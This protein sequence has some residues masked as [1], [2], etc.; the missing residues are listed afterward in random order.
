MVLAATDPMA[1][2]VAAAVRVVCGVHNYASYGRPYAFMPVSA[3]LA[4]FYILMLFIADIS[5]RRP[6]VNAYQADFAARQ[7]EVC[8]VALLAH[9]L[10]AGA[11]ASGQLPALT[12]H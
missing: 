8:R 7:F 9:K 6:A 10:Y 12:G 11:G 5:D 4:D 1:S 2:A 3:G